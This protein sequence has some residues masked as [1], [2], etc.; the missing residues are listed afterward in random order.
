MVRVLVGTARL[1]KYGPFLG[2]E[3]LAYVNTVASSGAFRKL[4]PAL[5]AQ[6]INNS[7]DIVVS[8]FKGTTINYLYLANQDAMFRIDDLLDS[9]NSDEDVT[10]WF[11]NIIHVQQINDA[12]CIAGYLQG[13][14]DTGFILTPVA[15]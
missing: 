12:G 13:S 6:D 5:W 4:E 2:D 14:L 7:G 3:R 9:A 10:L 11:S 15:P 1:A 8:G